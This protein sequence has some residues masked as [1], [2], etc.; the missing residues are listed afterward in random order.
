MKRGLRIVA[1]AAG[2]LLV[3]LPLMRWFTLGAVDVSG[4]EASGAVLVLPVVG[5][6]VTVIAA[7][8][9]PAITRGGATA[10][11]VWIA[12]LG[13]LALAISGLVLWAAPVRLES[14]VDGTTVRLPA[15]PV[16]ALAARGAVAASVVLVV[17]GVAGSGVRWSRLQGD[18]DG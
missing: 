7:R 1:A 10:E 18:P 8:R 12:L 13:L 4:V 2:L 15:E 16:P 14:R 5:V 17:L 3:V 11:A 9:G 6:L